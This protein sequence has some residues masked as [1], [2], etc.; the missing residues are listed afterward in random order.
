VIRAYFA[1]GSNMNPARVAARGLR[2]AAC[3]SARLEGVRLVFDKASNDHPECAHANLA[4][5]RNGVVEGVLYR[6]V[7]ADEIRKMD[8]FERTPIN[9]SRDAIVVETTHGSVNAWTYFA[10]PGVRR[11][12]LRPERAYLEHLLAGRPYLSAPYYSWLDRTPCH[13]EV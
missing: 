2:I 4:F 8:P 3:E 11:A 1:Y 13:G 12:G 6:L 10:N 5:G 7:D 9:Y